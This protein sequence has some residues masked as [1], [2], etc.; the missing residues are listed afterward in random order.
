[1]NLDNQKIDLLKKASHLIGPVLFMFIL[2]KF[3]DIN[4]LLTTLKTASLKHWFFAFLFNILFILG[5]ICRLH[6]LLNR[7]EIR[8]KYFYLSKI[9]AYSFLL[10]QISNVVVA[11]I[12]N[13]GILFKGQK[14]K[15]RISNIFIV[16]KAADF[17]MICAIFMVCFAMNSHILST[18]INYERT[19]VVFLIALLFVVLMGAILLSAKFRVFIRDFINT[20]RSFTFQIF[21]FTVIIYFF[22]A[23]SILNYAHAF[24]I[25]ISVSFLLLV[26]SLGNLITVLPISVSGVGTRDLTFIFLLNLVHI[27]SEK[28]LLLSLV[29]Y[30]LTPVLSITTIYIASLIGVKYENSNHR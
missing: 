9:Y 23:L 13:M 26:N 19:S 27:S 15:M 2:I 7:S 14:N 1:M 25:D 18:H 20:V 12:A 11:D 24:H 4:M 16:S 5:K 6:Y 29:S 3:I 28:A 30:I 22:S 10:G 21:V 8:I 17:L